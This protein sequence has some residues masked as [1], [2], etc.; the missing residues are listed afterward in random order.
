M[1]K[2]LRMQ[3]EQPD[4]CSVQEPGTQLG[5]PIQVLNL[6]DDRLALVSARAPNHHTTG[7]PTHWYLFLQC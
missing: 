7:V 5:P 1:R 3:A 6:P 4:R 2:I